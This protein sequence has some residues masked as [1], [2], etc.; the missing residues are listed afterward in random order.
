M[1]VIKVVLVILTIVAVLGISLPLSGCSCGPSFPYQGSYNGVWDGH[2]TVLTR[3]VPVGGSITMAVDS[4]GVVSGSVATTGGTVSPATFKGQVDENG[5][6]S[7]TV[8]FTISGTAFNSNWQGKISKAGS[9]FGLVGTWSSD[10]GSGTFSG[11]SK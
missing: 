1:K 4:K 2:L 3:S 10:H 7:G 6:L 8:S 11:N 9:T 5:N